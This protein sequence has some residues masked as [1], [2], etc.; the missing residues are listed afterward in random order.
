MLSSLQF[1]QFGP[2]IL[3]CGMYTGKVSVMLFSNI[4][5]IQGNEPYVCH[6]DKLEILT[7]IKKHEMKCIYFVKGKILLLGLINYKLL[8][9]FIYLF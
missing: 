7:T 6:D 5:E 9:I 8:H 3:L 1:L 4:C 2:V